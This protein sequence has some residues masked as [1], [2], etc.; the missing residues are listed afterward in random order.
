MSGQAVL[1]IRVSTAE[2]ASN[3][4]SLPLQE[5]KLRAYCNQHGLDVAKLFADRGE[6]ARTDD[7]PQFQKLLAYCRQ[8]RHQVSHLIV[9]DLSRLAR[10]VFDQGKIALELTELSIQLVSVDEQ[11]IDDSAAGRLLKN[12]LGSMNQFFS[13]SLS[14][15]T[16][17][18]MKAGVE[19]GRWLWVAP[20]G[21]R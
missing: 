5:A 8:H 3:N 6:S 13:D 20:I 9:S 12:V 4:Q 1:Y 21:Y 10:N 15:K 19:K 18:R 17:F 14:E 11:N 7:R 2:Q 16:R